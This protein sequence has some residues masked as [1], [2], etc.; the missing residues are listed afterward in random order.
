MLVSSFFSGVRDL[1]VAPSTAF[2]R[3]PTD[4]SQ[5]GL[6]VAKGTISLVSHSTS[7]FFG[8]M[9]KVAAG[10]GQGLAVVSLDPEFRTWHRDK[11]VTEVT[12]MNREWKRRGVQNVS[13]MI[14]RPLGDVAHGVISGVGGLVVAPLRGYRSHGRTGF[15]AGVGRG[16][17]GVVIRP[18]VGVLD[19]V[20]HFSA[21]VHDVAKSVN[22]LEKRY[23]PVITY[24]LPYSF[25]PMNILAAFNTDLTR[26][27]MVLKKYPMKKSHREAVPRDEKVVHMEV[28]P[29]M[30]TDT[31]VIVTCY[32]ILL[33]KMSTENGTISSTLSWTIMLSGSS[34][35]SSTVSEYGHNGVALTVTITKQEKGKSEEVAEAES[36]TDKTE[37]AGLEDAAEDS[38]IPLSPLG[39]SAAS[40][41]HDRG[42]ERGRK[43]ELLEWYTVLA[44]YQNRLQ[45]TKLH[46]AICC[47]VGD[48][49]SV[50]HD[51]S[52]GHV[53]SADGY[54]SFGLFH[55]R[56]DEV[57]STPIALQEADRIESLD[58]LRWVDKG[59]FSET[60]A[61]GDEEETSLPTWLELSFERAINM[62]KLELEEFAP[63]DSQVSILPTIVDCSSEEDSVDGQEVDDDPEEDPVDHHEKGL[64]KA[65]PLEVTQSLPNVGALD[66]SSGQNPREGLLRWKTPKDSSD[67]TTFF[68]P[69]ESA[70]E[71]PRLDLDQGHQSGRTLVASN[72]SP[73]DEKNTAAPEHGAENEGSTEQGTVPQRE[74][75]RVPSSPGSRLV[76]SL[77]TGASRDATRESAEARMDRMENLMERLL[78]FSAEQS[79]ANRS[80][81]DGTVTSI[82]TEDVEVM[83]RELDSLRAK[84]EEQSHSGRGLEQLREEVAN[85]RAQIRDQSTQGEIMSIPEE[86]AEEMDDVNGD[87]TVASDEVWDDAACELSASFSAA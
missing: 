35:V 79:I 52:L 43:G 48:F 86:V 87:T 6:G 26:A 57:S 85:L 20:A 18:T 68:S 46:N 59:V 11:I 45:L 44:E 4:A 16:G 75:D 69:L 8:F 17:I 66:P 78:I 2:M 27:D 13:A 38:E 81:Y 22:V 19:A 49:G 65:K 56:P 73:P 76:P 28:L 32:R 61:I 34:K 55:F 82:N 50:L 60:V 71:T 25:G 63:G 62:E 53:G 64:T 21:S 67:N 77:A 9:S 12:N 47:I 74:V 30:G 7:G 84:V 5:L 23:Q 14:T 83:R 54:T 37:E 41:D 1:V 42:L 58:S 36:A 72:T 15:I 40:L 51:P 10:A 31:F 24:R 3:S 70:T 80:N 33:I 39:K 29:N